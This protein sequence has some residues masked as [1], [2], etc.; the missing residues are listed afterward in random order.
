[1]IQYTHFFESLLTKKTFL[2]TGNRHSIHLTFKVRNG[3]RTG[4]KRKYY[5]TAENNLNYPEYNNGTVAD[6]FG[7][8]SFS[9]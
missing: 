3:G 2:Y 8:S 1:M 5:L 7:N 9:F 6:P 4:G